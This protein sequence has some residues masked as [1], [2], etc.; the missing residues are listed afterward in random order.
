LSKI[1]KNQIRPKKSLGQ[2]F[3]IDKNICNKIINLTNINNQ[4]VIEIGPGKGFL[5]DIILSKKPKNL[6]IIEKDSYLC[7]NLK[8]KYKNVK[9]IYVKNSDALK[10]NYDS[11]KINNQII[12]SN[13]PY[14]ISIKLIFNWLKMKNF[15]LEMILMIQKEVAEKMN[16][17]NNLKKNR[18]NCFI[19]NASHY[20]IE[21]HVSN[22]VFFPKP[23]VKSSVIKIIPKNNIDIDLKKFELFT[24]KIFRHK[25]KKLLNVLKKFENFSK[26]NIGEI[27]DK[28][29]EDLNNN[30]ILY[31]FNKFYNF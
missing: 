13:L 15:F 9:N 6:T 11:S 29:A 27:L 7:D 25:R 20:N 14:N 10:Y 24:N 1:E 3:I 4:N 16:Y 8:I 31:L 28:R 18:L 17:K 22:N 5:T 30:E 19:E 2:N 23:K 12:I 21:F 26:D